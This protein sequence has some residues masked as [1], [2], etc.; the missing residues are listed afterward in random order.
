MF[1]PEI[2][3]SPARSRS[4]SRWLRDSTAPMPIWR[5]H[6]TATPMPARVGRSNVPSSS[7]RRA[8]E[9]GRGD[10]A[11]A[12]L[13]LLPDEQHAG[14]RWCEQPLVQ[15]G[16]IQVAVVGGHVDRDAADRLRA[17]DGDDQAVLAPQAAHRVDRVADAAAGDVAEGQ[18]PGAAG[19]R[20]AQRLD[21]L[22]GVLDGTGQRHLADHRKRPA[23]PTL[24]GS[25]EREMVPLRRNEWGRGESTGAVTCRGHDA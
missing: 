8:V 4:A 5:S 17:V 24:R 10:R 2:S 7:Y 9:P 1:M 20:G 16:G 22:R 19:D 13:E 6:A 25:A 15:A 11:E 18:H 12:L 21:Q 14:T 23:N 3:A